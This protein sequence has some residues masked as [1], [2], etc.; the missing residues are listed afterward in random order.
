VAA[1]SEGRLGTRNAER[2]AMEVVSGAWDGM[3]PATSAGEA[4]DL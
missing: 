1:E 3:E 2:G 4:P